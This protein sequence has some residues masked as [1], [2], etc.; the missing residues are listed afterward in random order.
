MNE[1]TSLEEHEGELEL[2][3]MSIVSFGTEKDKLMS[4]VMVRVGLCK[5]PDFNLF[6][7]PN[8]CTSLSP[9]LNGHE[10]AQKQY[11]R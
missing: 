2:K 3:S 1:S 7:R 11:F 5:V 6:I 8:G 10:E 9:V 4:P